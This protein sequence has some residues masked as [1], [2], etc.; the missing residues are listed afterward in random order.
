MSPFVLKCPGDSSTRCTSGSQEASQA[1]D[2]V[3]TAETK[4]CYGISL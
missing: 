2:V 1:V 3:G 4:G